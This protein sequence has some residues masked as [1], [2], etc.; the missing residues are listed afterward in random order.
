LRR[1]WPLLVGI[2]VGTLVGALLLPKGGGAQATVWLG[3][4]LTIYAG[5][6]LVRIHFVALPE[7]EPWL[8]LAMGAATVHRFRRDHGYRAP[9]RNA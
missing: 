7:A 8:G 5:L 3:L 9:G 1:L 6:G 4:A 2:C